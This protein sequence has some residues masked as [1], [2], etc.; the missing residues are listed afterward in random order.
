[1]SK[2]APGANLTDSFKGAFLEAASDAVCNLDMSQ[3]SYR[4]DDGTARAANQCYT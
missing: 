4:A 2:A 1:M 3:K